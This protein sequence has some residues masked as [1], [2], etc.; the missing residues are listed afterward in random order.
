MV[1]IGDSSAHQVGVTSKVLGA[2]AERECG[3]ISHI[4]CLLFVLGCTRPATNLLLSQLE[5][6][7]QMRSE[8]SVIAEKIEPRVP[9][10]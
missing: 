2:A 10:F 3:V 6:M 4:I 7:R 8:E 9:S 5:V 1:A